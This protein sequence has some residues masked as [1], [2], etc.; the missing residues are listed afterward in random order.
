[1]EI[2]DKWLIMMG[3]T[4]MGDSQKMLSVQELDELAKRY[5]FH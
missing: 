4:R 3:P 2:K 5:L 1:M